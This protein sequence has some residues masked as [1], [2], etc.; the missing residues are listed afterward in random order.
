[1][2]NGSRLTSDLASGTRPYRQCWVWSERGDDRD[3][4]RGRSAPVVRT[5]AAVG[6]I[7]AALRMLE[8]KRGPAAAEALAPSGAEPGRTAPTAP[9]HPDSIRKPR[10]REL[11]GPAF[12]GVD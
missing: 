6:L 1:M 10:H 2:S 8:R 7:S 11:S 3:C 9:Q 5:I 12:L 4:G